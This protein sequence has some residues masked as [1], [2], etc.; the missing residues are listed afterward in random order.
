MAGETW[1]KGET[2]YTRTAGGP[3]AVS[4]RVAGKKVADALPSDTQAKQD[5]GKSGEQNT[6]GATAFRLFRYDPAA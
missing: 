5:W 1:T 4:K 2:T 6:Q 3:V